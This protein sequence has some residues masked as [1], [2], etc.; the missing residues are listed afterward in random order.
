MLTDNGSEFKNKEM[1]EVCDTLGLNIFSL[2]CTHHSQTDAWKDGIGS[3]K[4]A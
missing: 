1:Q 2:Q 4:F 3:L